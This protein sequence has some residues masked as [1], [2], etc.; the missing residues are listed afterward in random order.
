VCGPWRAQER[1][2]GMKELGGGPAPPPGYA[3]ASPG[4]R[5]A[6]L[7]Q[8][9]SLDMARSD[10][11]VLS[12]LRSSP[13]PPVCSGPTETTAPSWCRRSITRSSWLTKVDALPRGD[14][15]TFLHVHPPLRRSVPVNDQREKSFRAASLHVDRIRKLPHR[16]DR[17]HML[18]Q[19]GITHRIPPVDEPLLD[20][21]VQALQGMPRSRPSR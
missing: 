16:Q 7:S 2:E 5:C 3:C 4:G 20:V 12:H 6:L 1:R 13:H 17:I 10:L 15:V 14:P 21:R 11:Q 8:V 18:P 19:R 9:L